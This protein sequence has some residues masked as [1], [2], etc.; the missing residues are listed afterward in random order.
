[1]VQELIEL[2]AETLVV[3]GNLPVGC[4]SAYLSSFRSSNKKDYSPS[5]CLRRLNKFAKYH[6]QM[7]QNELNRLRTTHPYANI[8]YGDYYNAAAPIYR[9]PNEFGTC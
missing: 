6:N 5:G 8:I 1:M 4:S 3:P 9:S 7:L 2:G